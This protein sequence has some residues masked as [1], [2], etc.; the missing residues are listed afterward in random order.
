MIQ[1]Q[2][3]LHDTL[4]FIETCRNEDGGYGSRPGEKSSLGS[5]Y[6]AIIIKK[7]ADLRFQ[8]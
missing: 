2:K 8:K 1:N 4:G 5:T 7:W 3:M 6:H